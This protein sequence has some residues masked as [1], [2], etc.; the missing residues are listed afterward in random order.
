MVSLNYS[1][2]M[3]GASKHKHSLL[4]GLCITELSLAG[5]SSLS[6]WQAAVDCCFGLLAGSFYHFCVCIFKK[7]NAAVTLLIFPSCWV[8]YLRR[9]MQRLHV[10]CQG[11]PFTCP[12]Y[13]PFTSFCCCSLAFW[14]NVSFHFCDQKLRFATWEVRRLKLPR[15][16]LTL[17]Y[18]QLGLIKTFV[19]SGIHPRIIA[20]GSPCQQ[21]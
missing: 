1:A 21:T 11:A 14:T 12:I 2:A 3:W 8:T 17:V 7:A 20:G 9:L 18:F 10:L 4:V 13:M 16:D 5:T 6:V 19:L 15:Q